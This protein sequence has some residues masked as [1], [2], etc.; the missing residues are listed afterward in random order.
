MYE[1]G[2]P[3]YKKWCESVDEFINGYNSI[4]ASRTSKEPAGSEKF[5]EGWEVAKKL[6]GLS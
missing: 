5:K 3:E 2:T 1:Y 4:L 6:Y